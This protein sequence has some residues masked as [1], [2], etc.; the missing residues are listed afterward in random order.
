MVKL[1]LP[2]AGFPY[3]CSDTDMRESMLATGASI[4]HMLLFTL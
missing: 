2:Q 3:A 4:H 1:C